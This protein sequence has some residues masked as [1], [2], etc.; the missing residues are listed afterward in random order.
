M[1]IEAVRN[2]CLS[3]PEVTE[4]MPFGDTVL[5]FK[6]NEKIFLLTPLDTESFQMNVKCDPELAIELRAQWPCVL[7]G[8]HMNKQHW[9]TVIPDGSL[10]DKCI[11]EWID[12][13]YA[14]VHRSTVRKSNKPSVKT[15]K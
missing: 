15:K 12:H 2:Y 14:L 9:N 8:Y 7:P 10:P 13:S 5:V 1:N 3:K 4:G 6:V 11:L